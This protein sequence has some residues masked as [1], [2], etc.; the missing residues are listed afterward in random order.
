MCQYQ[1]IP[2]CADFQTM[3]QCVDMSTESTRGHGPFRIY[4]PASL[5]DAIRHYRQEAGLTQAELAEM[6]S[7][8]RSYLSRLEGGNETE[9][10]TR[11]FRIFRTLGVRMT[12]EKTDW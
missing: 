2:T 5:G 8:H 10:L 9:Q 12:L 7:I 6:V 11:M 3:I 4:T 1:D